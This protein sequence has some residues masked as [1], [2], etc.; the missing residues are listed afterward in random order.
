MTQKANPYS[1]FGQ[2]GKRPGAA[3][4]YS[5]A[6]SKRKCHGVRCSCTW[7][8]L[9]PGCTS[10]SSGAASNFFDATNPLAPKPPMFPGKARSVIYIHMAGAPSQLE[11][12][13][14]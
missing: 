1:T 7:F 3:T 13:S 8:A 11:L 12:F 10:N 5:Q 6:F 4:S 14:L 9:L 2:G